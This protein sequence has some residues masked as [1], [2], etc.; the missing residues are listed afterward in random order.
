MTVLTPAT[1][2][3]LAALFQAED[4]SEAETLLAEQCDETLPLLSGSGAHGLERVRFA[5]IRVSGGKLGRLREAIRV[6]Q[7]ALR[8]LLMAAKFA[9]H[10][11]AHLSWVPQRLENEVLRAWLR[12]NPPG[13]VAFNSNDRVQVQYGE[14]RGING[15][16]VGL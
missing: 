8:D 4:V 2:A 14:R 15:R 6:A 7:S 9:D 5:A 3:R 11:S 10:P 16:I 12:G 1:K 13:G